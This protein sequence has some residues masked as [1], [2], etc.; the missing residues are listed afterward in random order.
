MNELVAIG[1]GKFALEVARYA[2]ESGFRIER[3]LALEGEDIHAPDGMWSNLA[4]Y[5]PNEGTRVALAVSD[6]V[7]RREVIEG[8]ITA[9]ELEPVN[10]IH[11]SSHLDPVAIEG[12]GN[13]IGPDNYIGVN[14]VVGSYNVVN[15][16]CTFGHHSRI[17]S[18]NFFSPNF[19]CGNSVRIGEGNFFGL[20]CTV[21]PEICIGDE[22][23]F[24]AGITFFEDA[25]SGF[26][27]LTPSRIKSIKS[28]QS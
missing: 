9:R 19:H 20:D 4:E 17:G 24:Q 15:Y 26:S 11:P 13:V 23:R 6:M 1:A 16:R 18:G 5:D 25:A 28:D 8:Y 22:C 3:Y 2:E 10:I 14:T 7:L 21:A 27:Y 12:G